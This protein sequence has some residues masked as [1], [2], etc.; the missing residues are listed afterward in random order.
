MLKKI[1]VLLAGLLV[2]VAVYAASSELRP[3]HPDTYVVKKGDTLWD[4][5]AHFLRKPW[6]WPEIWQANPQVHNPHLIY[7]GDVLDLSYLHGPVLKLQ[8]KTRSE[9]LSPVPAIPLSDLKLFLRD[10]RVVSADRI[11]H[12]PY[13]VGF[14]ENHL[15]GVDGQFLYVRD[16]QAQPGKRFAVVRPSH[17][18]RAFGQ[19]RDNDIVSHD[20]DSDV[21]MVS[22]PWDEDYRNDG[23][24]GRGET[25]G[26]EARVIGTAEVL[27]SGDTAT[28]LLTDQSREIRKGDRLLPVN[29]HP[30]D[31]SYYPHAPHSLPHNGRVIELADTLYAVGKRQVVALSVGSDQNVNNGTTFSIFQ[32][33]QR[34]ANDVTADPCC[35][36]FTHHIRLPSE[37]VGH[38]MVFRTFQHVS[39]GLIMDDIRPVRPGDELRMPQ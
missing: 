6:L 26:V 21:A 1:L 28:L 34:I 22:S 29:D 36:S 11:K 25:L 14:E 16:L 30:Y 35:R 24:Y 12:A 10:M 20:I 17:V 31:A 13:V 9:D 33:G 15:R 39:Y 27:R 3:D 2:T 38:V 37:Y 4:I 18:F 7:P 32:P 8:P 19:P 5:S 23:H